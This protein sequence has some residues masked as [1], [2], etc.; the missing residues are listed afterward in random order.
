MRIRD[1]LKG[2]K[3]KA[4]RGAGE[5][6]VSSLTD[7]SRNA[8][9]GSLFIAKRGY[10]QDGAKFIS[11]A[12]GKGAAAVAAEEDFEAPEGVAKILVRDTRSAI[13][14]MA[15]NFYGHPSS[16]LK[17]AGITGTNGKTTITY[18]ME[19]IIKAAGGKAGVIGTIN[20]R[21]GEKVVPAKNTTPGPIELQS[22]LAEMVNTGI[23][24]A[25]MEVSSHSLDQGRVD[26]VLFDAAVFTN[27]TGDHLDYHKTLAG[28][29]RAKK[30]L[31]EK[32]KRGG[33]AVLNGDDKKVASLRRVLKRVVV[34]G[35]KKSA[36]VRAE[37]IKLS[38][39]GSSFTVKTPKGSFGIKTKL[40]GMHNV[41]NILAAVAAALA[42]KIPQDAIARGVENLAAVP[43]RLEAVDMGQ[44]FKV[45]VDFAHTEDAL[46]NVLSLL[47][48]VAERRI[49]TVFGCGGN[50]DRTK[51]PRMGRVACKF[52][53]RVIITSDNPRFEEPHDIAAEIEGGIKGAFSNYDIV[54]DRHEAIRK[55]FEAAGHGDIVVLAGKGHETSQIIRDK[56]LPFDDREV[57]R[58]VLKAKYRQG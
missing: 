10:S 52:S 19:S 46:F 21:L 4:G 56:A 44:P 41:S 2:V 36:D 54:V 43:G 47:R 26:S 58:E 20:Y 14:V 40:I 3:F 17:V 51:R 11:D 42:L 23:G 35:T 49:V 30:R 50:R 34:Y 48:G 57:A 32:L 27:I 16:G 28:Y 53:D 1:I 15:G 7:D 55:A 5:L 33:T 18:L 25:V 29:F 38:M 45:F 13:P 37:D 39:S 9:K 24:Y 22:M 31:F 6:D 8:A 12:V